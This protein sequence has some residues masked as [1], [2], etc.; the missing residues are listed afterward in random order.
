M[1]LTDALEKLSNA[2][3]VTGKEDEV[4]KCARATQP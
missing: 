4:R 2:C 3:E 1:K